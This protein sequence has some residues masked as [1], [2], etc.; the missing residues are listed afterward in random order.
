MILD[1]VLVRLI[2]V[3][4][5]IVVYKQILGDC[6][7]HGRSYQHLSMAETV[8]IAESAGSCVVSR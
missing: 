7:L 2:K 4:V 8:W 1:F 5:L 3:V 6:F